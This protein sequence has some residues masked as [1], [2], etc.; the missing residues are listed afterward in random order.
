MA[1]EPQ[2]ADLS[3]GHRFLPARATPLSGASNQSYD[4]QLGMSFTQ[5]FAS[6]AYNVTAV[7]QADPVS[8]TGPAYLLNGLTASGYWYQV[9]LAW[10]W[11]PGRFPGTGW[12][13][14]YEVFDSKGN[15]VLPAGGGGGVAALQGPVNQGDRITLSLSF[16]K[17]GQVDM[18]ATDSIT[19]ASAS[20]S[21]SAEGDTQFVG[22][23]GATADSNGFFTGLMTE[24]Y[25]GAAY[26]GNEAAVNFTSGVPLSSAWMWADEFQ[27]SG[28]DCANQT[29]LF[30]GYT[31]GPVSYT[32]PRQV[33]EFSSHGVT[34]YSDAYSLVTGSLSLVSVTLSYSVVG[35]GVNQ[36]PPALVYYQEGVLQDVSLGTAPSSYLMDSGSQWSVPPALPGS[37]ASERWETDQATSGVAEPA[38][39]VV[40]YYTH[41][42]LVSF[43]MAVEG[44]GTGYSAPAV[45]YQEFGAERTAT[46]GVAVWA[47]AG[48]AV[49]FPQILQGSN[50]TERW[51][52]ARQQQQVGGP[53]ASDIFPST[54]YRQFLATLGYSTLGG[55]PPSSPFVLSDQFGAAFA[56][57]LSITPSGYWIDFGARWSVTGGSQQG[58]GDLFDGKGERWVDTG[59]A[60]GVVD[61]SFALTFPIQHQYQLTVTGSPPQGGANMSSVMW[62]DDGA[63]VNLSE[64]PAGGWQFEG[65]TGTGAGAYTGNRSS[66]EFALAGAVNETALYYPG[67]TIYLSGG[68]SVQYSYG[69]A[70]GSVASTGTIYLPSGTPVSLYAS[71]SSPFYDFLGWGGALGGGA[72]HQAVEVRSP[73]SVTADF[74]YN[75]LVIGGF[76]LAAVLAGTG[77]FLRRRRSHGGAPS[78]DRDPLQ[79]LE[80]K[81]GPARSWTGDFRRVRATS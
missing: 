3:G 79:K 10:N 21:Y 38:Q 31:P 50:G 60:S 40:F 25:H 62:Y 76:S 46:P 7:E 16:T 9:G 43:A 52:S 4:E 36:S 47:D 53:G 68:G 73:S 18:L 8:G 58:S 28:A 54:Y 57:R 6:M 11:N 23:P 72:S 48:S 56:A 35:G 32:S 33:R 64:T 27:C 80:D 19:G 45:G 5:D 66:A 14:V 67:L 13:M 24:W 39:T 37:D 29:L 63:D 55:A 26:Y 71:P 49:S 15:T 75:W 74:G 77:L 59:P 78:V 69:G 34:E 22:T 61:S 42:D 41:Q 17:S 2:T 1:A 12:D 65:W 51:A 70:V 81:D 20:E 44:G 30:S